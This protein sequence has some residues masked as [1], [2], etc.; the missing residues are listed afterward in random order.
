M[1]AMRFC[2]V[3]TSYSRKSCLIEPF[4]VGEGNCI[5]GI[6]WTFCGIA[7]CVMPLWGGIYGGLPYITPHYY[8]SYA[9]VGCIWGILLYKH[10][11]LM[12]LCRSTLG[13]NDTEIGR[14]WCRAMTLLYPTILRD[15]FQFADIRS[16]GAPGI[17]RWSAIRLYKFNMSNSGSS[18]IPSQSWTL[19][20]SELFYYQAWM[21]LM[22]SLNCSSTQWNLL[23][24]SVSGT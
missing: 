7:T 8:M 15:P 6:K 5:C 14:G 10:K 17:W 13:I 22:P 24:C 11:W 19:T 4:L 1:H 20:Q 2:V 9:L 3:L 21:I 18:H 23:H 12:S 16:H